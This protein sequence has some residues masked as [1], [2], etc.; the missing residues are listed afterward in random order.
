LLVRRGIDAASR[1]QHFDAERIE[2]DHVRALEPLGV[3]AAL[4]IERDRLALGG[5]DRVLRGDSAV[6]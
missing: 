3:I 4:G 6:R 2:F 5:L 1:A